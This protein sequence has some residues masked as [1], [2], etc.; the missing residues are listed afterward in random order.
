MSKRQPNRVYESM[1]RVQV[2]PY[3]VRV[4]RTEA[5]L[6][7]ADN[8]DLREALRYANPYG[9]P[10]EIVRIV[11]ALPRI[12]AVEVLDHNGNGGILYPDWS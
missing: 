6:T 4:W 2:G 11:E 1:T 5:S 3:T 9:A 8:S 12:A 7:S 10:E